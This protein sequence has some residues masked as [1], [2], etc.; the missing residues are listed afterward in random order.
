VSALC[1]GATHAEAA[2]V[3]NLCASVTIRKLGTTG[4]ASPDELRERLA[5]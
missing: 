4:T 2:F 3:G 1:T 5:G